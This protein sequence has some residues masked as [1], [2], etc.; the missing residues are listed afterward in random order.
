MRS[1]IEVLTAIQFDDEPRLEADKVADIDA[2]WM[3]PPEFESVELSTA[4]VTPEASLSFR[5]IPAQLAGE[6]DHPG[7]GS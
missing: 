3:L 7:R 4:Q 5:Q 2:E 6:V 1:L